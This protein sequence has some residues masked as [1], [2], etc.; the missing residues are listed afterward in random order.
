MTLVVNPRRDIS[1]T[2][3]DC[4]VLVCCLITPPPHPLVADLDAGN[5][6]YKLTERLAG[7]QAVGPILQGLAR[8]VNDL[9]RGCTADDIA[10]AAAVTALQ[11]VQAEEAAVAAFRARM[12][13]GELPVHKRTTDNPRTT[14]SD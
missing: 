8:P 3:F 6:A 13:L 14:R 2:R 12:R 11:S 1:S 4:F 5:I 9:S 7:A 10:V